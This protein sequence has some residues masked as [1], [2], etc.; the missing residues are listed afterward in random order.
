[1]S[2]GKVLFVSKS[3]ICRS[4]I[5]EYV[6]KDLIAG[7]IDELVECDSCATDPAHVG[8]DVLPEAVKLIKLQ[9][10]D[11]SGKKARLLTDS[12]IRNSDYIVCMDAADVKAV[13]ARGITGPKIG[14][15]MD[16]AGGGEIPVI[17]NSNDLDD[18]YTNIIKGCTGLSIQVVF[19][20]DEGA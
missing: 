16:Y 1:M 14:L 5:A 13:K 9:K 6:F 8:D 7:N 10:Q 15:L 11:C 2:K 3:N 20:M 4:P 12:D 17:S 18:A 19:D